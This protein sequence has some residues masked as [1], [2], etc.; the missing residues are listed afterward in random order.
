MAKSKLLVAQQPG[1][2]SSCCGGDES[3]PVEDDTA[4]MASTSSCCGSDLSATLAGLDGA[5][6]SAF[7]R[8]RKP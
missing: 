7:I 8:A 2:G 3:V 5:G 4:E 6:M 1:D